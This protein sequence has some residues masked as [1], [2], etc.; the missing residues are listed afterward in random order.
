MEVHRPALMKD[1]GVWLGQLEE[2]ALRDFFDLL[3]AEGLMERDAEALKQEKGD[4]VRSRAEVARKSGA[5]L[6]VYASGDPDRSELDIVLGD[7]RPAGQLSEVSR[8]AVSRSWTWVDL[9]A[10]SK[11]YP[12]VRSLVAL[13][14]LEQ[15]LIG[16]MEQDDLQKI[17]EVSE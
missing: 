17:A 3:V 2:S 16:W 12:E 6:T 1:S 10:D 8:A 9:Y 11:R 7:Y 5:P 4:A 15:R 14:E 13:G